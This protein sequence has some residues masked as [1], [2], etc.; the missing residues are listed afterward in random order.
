MLLLNVIAPPSPV[1]RSFLGWKLKQAISEIFP[2]LIFLSPLP[3]AQAPS[4]IKGKLFFLQISFILCIP[5]GFPKASTKITA[6]VLLVIFSSNSD[7]SMLYVSNDTS[8]KI[9][10]APISSTT[11]AVAGNE[12]SETIISSPSATFNIFKAIDSAV[13][14]EVVR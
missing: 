5:D 13:V 10:M 14:A 4:S 1:V 7:G 8:A 3:I 9:G 6:L 12:K 11:F 2:H